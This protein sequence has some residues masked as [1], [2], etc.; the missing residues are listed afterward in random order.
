MDTLFPPS[1]W[2]TFDAKIYKIR[3]KIARRPTTLSLPSHLQA[4]LSPTLHSTLLAS[5]IPHS[6]ATAAMDTTSLSIMPNF[7]GKTVCGGRIRMVELLG[8]GTYGVVYS[9]VDNSEAGSSSSTASPSSSSS[10]ALSGSEPTPKQYAVKI[11]EKA[12]PNTLL[13][14]YQQGEISTHLRVQKHKNIVSVHNVYEDPFFVYIVLE[15]CAGGTLLEAMIDRLDMEVAECVAAQ[16]VP[17]EP[18]VTVKTPRRVRAS[19]TACVRCR[20]MKVRCEGAET[21]V[22]A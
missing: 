4:S 11:M 2:G 6:H 17:E 5:S 15:Y 16:V 12:Q 7:S 19:G 18:A 22:C 14:K 10:S 20:R 3:S 1:P 8:E 13:W 9:A 21:V